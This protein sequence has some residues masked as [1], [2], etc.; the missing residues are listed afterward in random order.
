MR[1]PDNSTCSPMTISNK[2]LLTALLFLSLSVNGRA[3][4]K[5]AANLFGIGY[6]RQLDTYLSPEHY[7][8]GEVRYVNATTWLRPGCHWARQMTHQV[9]VS[10]TKT[11]TNDNQ[12]IGGMYNF[13]F[14]FQRKLNAIQ[15]GKGQL[16]ARFGGGPDFWLGALYNT[17]NGNNPA[18][19][20]VALRLTPEA[21]VS[22]KFFSA[23][24]PWEAR[25]NLAM[26]IVGLQF[27]PNYGQSYYEI[28]T[29][30]NY[31]HNVRATW[32]GSS[33]TFT[34]RLT[35]SIPV[36]K[37]HITLGYLTDWQQVSVNHLKYLS[38][39][40]SLLIGWTINK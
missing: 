20:R 12:D 30:D 10:Y 22:Y 26:P 1:L 8:G 4:H 36:A 31:D 33:P 25:I 17:R 9:M 3:Q 16:E 14:S 35:L 15:L 13:R 37:T 27:S 2:L 34:T 18:Q 11:R 5:Q 38:Y 29:R 19:A 21:D 7:S 23:G 6:N 40:H 28:F 32:M 24:K 39:T